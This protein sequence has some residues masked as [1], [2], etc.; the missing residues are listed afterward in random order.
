VGY[1]GGTKKN[2]NYGDLGDHSETVQIDFDPTLMTYDRLL[3]V[4]WHSH[5]PTEPAWSRQYRSII[6]YHN[7]AQR[8]SAA[9]SVEKEAARRKGRIVTELRPAGTFTLA[10]DYHQKHDL[11]M[12]SVFVREFRAMYPGKEGFVHSTA[13]ARINGY[14]GSYGTLADLKAELP[15]FGLSPEAARILTEIV[16]R[17]NG[18]PG[19][20][21]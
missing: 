4:F 12:E 14:L 11:R 2:P 6:F 8:R 5:D 18:R 16:S 9:E 1:A 7:E 19:C 3:E 15:G 13:A 10:E 20:P 17:R 21:L